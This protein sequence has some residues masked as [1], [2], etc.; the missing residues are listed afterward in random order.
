MTEELANIDLLK[1]GSDGPGSLASRSR[2]LLAIVAFLVIAIV[3]LGAAYWYLRRPRSE[4]VGPAAAPPADAAVKVRQDQAELIPLPPLA[5]TDP[6]VRQ[7]VGA[8]S[9]N[10]VVT[11]WL[12]TDRLIVNFVVVTSKIADG[13]TPAAELKA[14]GP[15]PPFKARTARGTLSID[16]SSYHR[17]DGYAQAVSA[18]DAQGTARLYETLKPRINEADRNFGGSGQF[19]AEMERAIVELLKVPIVE[20]EVALRMSG[21]GY[22]FADPRLE[23]LSPAQKQLL[24][25]GPENVKAIQGKLREIASLLQIPESR[26]PPPATIVSDR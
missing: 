25:M 22:A 1:S 13:Q 18:L 15:V 24:R 5:E 26:L 6:L 19:D 17:Y 7:L 23:G 8:L 2:R 10:P 21:I 12:T 4:S 11:A 20:G 14:V 16:P 9:S 3:V